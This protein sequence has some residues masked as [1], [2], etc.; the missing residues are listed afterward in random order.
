[1]ATLKVDSTTL[2]ARGSKT[3]HKST[4]CHTSEDWNRN[5]SAS[6]RDVSFI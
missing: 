3:G 2:M 6:S 5:K 4:R 1:M